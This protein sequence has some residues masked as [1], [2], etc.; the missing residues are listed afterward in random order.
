MFEQLECLQVFFFII[1][2][3]RIYVYI[4]ITTITTITIIKTITEIT[5]AIKMPAN[6]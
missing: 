2:L 3:L 4:A 1:N 5:I 6:F